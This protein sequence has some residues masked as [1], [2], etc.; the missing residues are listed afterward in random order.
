MG[1]WKKVLHGGV[2]DGV[3]GLE[4]LLSCDAVLLLRRQGVGIEDHQRRPPARGL[5]LELHLE[6]ERVLEIR[7]QARGDLSRETCSRTWS[8]AGV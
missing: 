6:T 3:Y 1:W 4:E 5:D 8:R 2:L 7:G